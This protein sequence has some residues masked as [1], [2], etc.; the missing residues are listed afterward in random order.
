MD[1]REVWILLFSQTNRWY[2]SNVFQKAIN[3]SR[4]GR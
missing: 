1:L 3:S 4:R 2:S